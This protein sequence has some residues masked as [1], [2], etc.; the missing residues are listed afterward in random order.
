[1]EETVATR[2][3]TVVLLAAKKPFHSEK[4][5]QVS[6]A[7]IRIILFAT[8]GKAFNASARVCLHRLNYWLSWKLGGPDAPARV[9]FPMLRIM[10]AQWRRSDTV[11][12][13]VAMNFTQAIQHQELLSAT[14][15]PALANLFVRQDTVSLYNGFSVPRRQAAH[16]SIF[17]ALVKSRMAQQ[18]PGYWNMPFSLFVEIPLKTQFPYYGKNHPN[19]AKK[20]NTIIN[21]SR[22]RPAPNFHCKTSLRIITFEN[23]SS[24]Y[25]PLV[26]L[27]QSFVSPRTRPARSTRNPRSLF[28]FQGYPVKLLF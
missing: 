26:F 4:P 8:V 7:P 14:D 9:Y 15:M 12:A 1:M 23:V 16:A 28:H 3:H 18:P 6:G 11:S 21:R 19:G 27:L 17:S 5:L 10:P 25:S 22:I 20:E 13:Q 2:I 24:V